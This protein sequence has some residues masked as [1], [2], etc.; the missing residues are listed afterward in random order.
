MMDFNAS[1]E[2]I[3]WFRDRYRAGTL[4][5]RPPFQRKP[6]WT[7]KQKCSLI[8]SILLKLPVPEIFVQRTVSNDGSTGYA[9][10]DGQQRIRTILQF[11]G[12][13]TDPD[14]EEHNRFPL[15]K[16]PATSPWSNL[17]FDEL[18]EDVRQGLYSY[19]FA[20]R[21]LNISDDA[22]IRDVFRRL[23]QFL[24]PLTAQEL[25][26]AMYSGPFVKMVERLAD[27]DYWVENRFFSPAIIRRMADIEF[28]S[29][30]VI[31]VLHGPQGGSS[32]IVDEYYGEYEEYDTEFPEQRTATH[33]FSKTLEALT[34]LFPSIKDSRWSN[35]TDFYSLF[36]AVAWLLRSRTLQRRQVTRLRRALN[37]F[38]EEIYLRLGNERARVSRNAIDYVR[39]VQRGANV[40]G[41]RADRHNAIL[42]VIGPFFT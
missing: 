1:E 23:N 15:D 9:V 12:A 4:A 40:K 16:L 27:D 21:Y 22:A 38:E 41:R 31:G 36:I 33:L 2:T 37:D 34:G 3:D 42:Q 11:I 5:I 8:E 10:V 29:E 19:R 32:R 28:V 35:R 30:L 25:R 17:T 39:A 24:T 6:V 26:H 18:D 13:E 14:E 7:A 20:V